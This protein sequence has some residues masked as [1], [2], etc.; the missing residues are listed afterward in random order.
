M[1]DI[2]HYAE[3]LGAQDYTIEWIKKRIPEN[4]DIQEAEH[5]ID[6]MLSDKAPKRLE[7]ATYE[8]MKNNTEK[9]NKTLIK[10]GKKVKETE[11]DVEVIL[12]FGD[13][14]KFVKLVG[15]KSYEREGF[16]MR[17]CVAS[18]FG[19]DTE[20]YSLRDNENNPHC[21]I[22]KDIQ[23]KGKGNGE[24]HPKYIAQ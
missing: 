10:K 6:Y 1:N 3:G 20:I 23:I 21:T 19:K 18:Y 2:L 13:G 22:E 15:K 11:D 5:V 8:Q 9:W 17:H 24:I 7:H 14:F 4:C 12:D 16:L